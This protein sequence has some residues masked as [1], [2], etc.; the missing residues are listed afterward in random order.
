MSKSLD[1][2]YA[3]NADIALLS[4]GGLKRLNRSIRFK[5]GRG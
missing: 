5:Q 3:L 1:E 4:D 2:H